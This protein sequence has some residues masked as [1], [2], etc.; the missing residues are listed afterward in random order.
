LLLDCEACMKSRKALAG[1]TQEQINEESEKCLCQ[2]NERLK[3]LGGTTKG[4]RG[5]FPGGF[6]LSD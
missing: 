3:A 5:K 4:Y 6:R 2:V 1:S